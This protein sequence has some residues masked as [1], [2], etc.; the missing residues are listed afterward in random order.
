MLIF[1]RFLLI[2]LHKALLY[3]LISKIICD[4]LH[5]LNYPNYFTE[6]NFP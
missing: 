1:N 6:A 4:F 3:E 5:D 2:F